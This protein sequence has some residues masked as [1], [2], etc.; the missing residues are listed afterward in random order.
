[1]PQEFS[2]G[3]IVYNNDLFLLLKYKRGHWGF[4]KGNAEQNETK[5]DVAKREAKEEAG[6]LDLYF[7]KRFEEKEEYFYKKEG[8]TVHKEV[9]YLLAETRMEYVRLSEEHVGFDWF[10]YEDAMRRLS[11]KQT[12][13][14]LEKAKEFLKQK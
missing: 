6:L 8:Q 13:N 3:V 11:F 10:T 9:I 4:V 7:V 5:E 1:M 14:V 12:K 2:V